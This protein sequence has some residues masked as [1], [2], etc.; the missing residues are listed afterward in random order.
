MHPESRSTGNRSRLRTGLLCLVVIALLPALGLLLFMSFSQ[1]RTARERGAAQAGVIA[2][3]AAND[4]NDV[5]TNAH[6]FMR[7]LA[8]QPTIVAGD[9]VAC[10]MMFAQLKA[11]GPVYADVGLAGTDGRVIACALPEHANAD[12][13]GTGW[14]PRARAASGFVSAG[15]RFD[16]RSGQED[17]LVAIPVR[18]ARGITVGVLYSDLDLSRVA[19]V[20]LRAPT[21][22]GSVLLLVDARGTVLGRWPRSEGLVG[23]TLPQ[24]SPVRA[25]LGASA[26]TIEALDLHQVRRVWSIERLHAA[27]LAGGRLALGVARAAILGESDRALASS[28]IALALVVFVSLAASWAWMRRA[29]L[30]PVDALVA[31]TGRLRG[32]DLAARSGL[33]AEDGELGELARA[34]DAMAES[35]QARDRDAHEA[36]AAQ[37]EAN[38]KLQALL[39]A[40]PLAIMALDRDGNVILW[41]P[42]AE[43][44]YGWSAD[45]VIG[46]RM[47][48]VPTERAAEHAELFQRAIQGERLNGVVV[49]R[50]RKDGASIETALWSAPL[51]R[52]DGTIY[53]TI[54]LA[55]DVTERRRLEDHLHQSQK[56]QAVGRLAGGLAHD[57]NNLLTVIRGF[58]DLSLKTP[59]LPEALQANLGQIGKAV[60]RAAALTRQL[61][62]FSRSPVTQPQALDLNA[63][64]S[65]TVRLLG[66]LVGEDVTLTLALG[67]PLGRVF[68]DGGQLA[69]VIT[70]LVVN[71]R[72]ALAPGGEIR[73]IT[74]DVEIRPGAGRTRGALRPGPHVA[75]TIADNG[76]GMDAETLQHVFEP[77]FTTKD[78]ARG[79]GLGLAS[80]YGIVTQSGGHVEVE[81]APGTGTTF[82]VLWP[83]A[84]NPEESGDELAD[85]AA[86]GAGGTGT[87]LIVEDEGA[88][89]AV[90]GETLRRAGYTVL[91]ASDGPSA[92]ATARGHQGTI[93][94]LIS[95][96]V[97]PGMGGPEVAQ[98]IERERSG[99]RTLF[100]SGH[101]PRTFDPD[102]TLRRG[103]DFLL[104]PFSLDALVRTVRGILERN[105]ERRA[106]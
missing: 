45:E 103:A 83:H 68:M 43:R 24:A 14:F 21:P 23:R 74:R 85:L 3:I 64:V 6:D 84:A 78:P 36:A 57:F 59:D 44:V 18:D 29:I 73:V 41:T 9:P 71:A 81:S 31:A 100:M 62:A 11:M 77:F 55:E 34:F 69:Q 12:L 93:D 33:E 70:N 47:P 52:P 98:A 39:T 15:E 65:E 66:P 46:R 50:R 54:G 26:A 58:T 104:K 8:T 19:T 67:E 92:I 102:G 75:L 88:V 86:L 53:G 35:L 89:R 94:L 97:M 56:M 13:A 4:V 38:Q 42:A 80:V 63:A 60:A 37:R 16:S 76:C 91:E 48:T 17:L 32:G 95:D 79:T 51:C 1:R 61:L 90:V 82:T 5:V 22:D 99:L 101:A 105:G 49:R 10:G 72:D 7:A 106:A 87:V 25:V 27:P 96:V 28:L 30:G 20:A 2:R 40:A